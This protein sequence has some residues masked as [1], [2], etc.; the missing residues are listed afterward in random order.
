MNLEKVRMECPF[1][2]E[3]IKPNAKICRFCNNEISERALEESGFTKQCP[4]CYKVLKPNLEFCL[5]CGI[6][7]Y[8]CID[9]N[10]YVLKDDKTCSKCGTNFEDENTSRISKLFN[11]ISERKIKNNNA[12]D[13]DEDDD[14][15]PSLQKNQTNISIDQ[16]SGCLAGLLQGA[17]CIVGA[18]VTL[19]ILLFLL[20]KACTA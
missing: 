20:F 19:L 11:K 10:S 2:A 16:S 13:I 8:E 7:L 18:I 1:C 6:E 12:L 17:G 5:Y 14:R 9:C 3:L 15:N 4:S